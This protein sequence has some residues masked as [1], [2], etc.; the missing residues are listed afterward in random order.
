MLRHWQYNLNALFVDTHS[1]SHWV[2]RN[3]MRITSRIVPSDI[4]S[5]GDRRIYSHIMMVST[6]M[7]TTMIATSLLDEFMVLVWLRCYVCRTPNVPLTYCQWATKSN[8][9]IRL[10]QSKTDSLQ[11]HHWLIF[12][13][14]R[15][16]LHSLIMQ[17]ID[18]RVSQKLCWS[19][20]YGNTFNFSIDHKSQLSINTYFYQAVCS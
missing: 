11:N 10:A 15:S 13:V 9:L 19:N 5:N 2:C 1:Y 4:A 6:M 17:I 16:K 18:M 7:T 20:W 14:E 8:Q 3:I 12:T